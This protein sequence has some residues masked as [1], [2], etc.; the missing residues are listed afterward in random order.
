MNTPQRTLFWR[1]G[2]TDHSCPGFTLVE[3][4]A[5]VTIIAAVSALSLHLLGGIGSGGNGARGASAIAA[6]LL[7][8]AREEAI[9]RRTTAR[10]LIDTVYDA[11]NPPNYL[12][13]LTV[14]YLSPATAT[15]TLATSWLQADKW[16]A[17]PG[18]IYVYYSTKNGQ[19]N[20]TIPSGSGMAVNFGTSAA[21]YYDYIEFNPAGQL[22]P[23]PNG[24][25][26]SIDLGARLHQ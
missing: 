22:T 6:S 14:A 19:N 4:L 26:R 7:G 11:N 8:T 16:E 21:A 17:L 23:A 1:R 20:G 18:N 2:Q 3:L 13:R 5:V 24:V 10:I 25:Q 12:H 9:M 15:P